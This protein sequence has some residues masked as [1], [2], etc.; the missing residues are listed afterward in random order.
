MPYHRNATFI[1]RSADLLKV[2]AHLQ[3]K[4]NGA[5]PKAMVISGMG[6]L[7]KTQLAVEYAYRYGRFF[8]GGVYWLNF[9]DAHNISEEVAAIGGEGY[10]GLYREKEKLTLGQKVKRVRQAWQ[11]KT[12][13]L[14]IF[15]SC[16]D[17]TVAATWMPR[18]GSCRVL[19]TSRRTAWPKEM[20]I[21][22]LPLQTL[23]RAEST[24]LLQQLADHLL[25]KEAA[26][27]AAEVG[28]LPLALQLAGHF[29]GK[30]K[31]IQ[32]QIYLAQLRH[33]RMLQHPSLRGEFSRYSP[34]GHE[35]HVART[36]ALSFDQLKDNNIIDFMSKQILAYTACLAPNEPIPLILLQQ[37]F[38]TD[39]GDE[40]YFEAGIQRLLVLGF[41]SIPDDNTVAI[42]PLIATFAMD[43]VQTA[44]DMKQTKH[45]VAQAMLY[46]LQQYKEQTSSLITLPFAT[47]HLRFVIQQTRANGVV[48]KLL[49][50]L[51]EHLIGLADYQ[52]AETCLQ[53]AMRQS[54]QFYGEET[55]PTADIHLNFSALYIGT[56]DYQGAL[57]HVEAALTIHKN[58]LGLYH[59]QTT[60]S[61][62]A[63]GN[64]R[65]RLG[66]YEE[67]YPYFEQAAT[68]RE[69]ILGAEHP[70][71]LSSLNNVAVMLN[72]MGNHEAAR[73]Y[74]ERVLTVR[75]RILE[76]DDLR[77][78]TTLNNFGDFLSRYFAEH[79][80]G[81][82][83][84]E[85]AVAIRQK[86][87]G[88]T[89]PLTLACLTNL[90]E[91]LN[92]QED[93]ETGYTYLTTALEAAMQRLGSNH[94]LTSR[95]LNTLGVT[96]TGLGDF[97]AAQD[98]LEKALSIRESIHGN[99]HT[100]VAYTLI[101]LGRLY[102][103]QGYSEK[104]RPNYQRALSI[105]EQ[106]VSP[107]HS[108]IQLVSDYLKA[109]EGTLRQ[110]R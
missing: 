73:T 37:I 79:V 71:T 96:L 29:L 99:V 107:N 61:L 82:G 70:L 36:F 75:E 64:I 45:V 56:A 78:A 30:N 13:R 81:Q 57:P 12:P 85:R 58:K 63:M 86:Q 15:D 43:T 62:N 53:Q 5:L 89:H 46:Q 87:L 110:D 97:S 28:D 100:N 66:S 52:E 19:L 17:E 40:A 95:I 42:H 88:P 1:G 90:G 48:A 92:K 44:H 18:F 35:L 105:L 54:R 69:T 25:T 10:M 74:F 11:E 3:P 60:S 98:K 55:L 102:D 7:G 51:A 103:A 27:I 31:A 33:E 59:A 39:N 8:P 34:T 23:T 67:A 6:G 14:L 104:A 72:Y 41:L 16:E 2:A 108:Y 26:D 77:L 94:P 83:Y 9:A 47:V 24:T 21:T 4:Q 76:P 80:T 91:V 20:P 49:N 22:E 84:L 65:F 106:T 50:L 38:L 109:A 101:C 32:P 68:I 93:F